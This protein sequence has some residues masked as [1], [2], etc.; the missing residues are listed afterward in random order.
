MAD[1]PYFTV[2]ELRA[3][4]TPDFANAGQVPGREARARPRLRRAVVRGR[5]ARR[6]RAPHRRGDADRQRARSCCSC[7]AGPRSGRSTAVTIDGAALTADELAG[8]RDA[9]LR[10]ASSAPCAWPAGADRRGHVPHGTRATT[11]PFGEL[12]KR[13]VMMLAAEHAKPSTIPARATS[14]RP[15]SAA[16]ASARPTRPARPASPTSTPII[17]LLGAD[18]P[19]TG[20]GA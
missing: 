9:P 4:H 11:E 17:G 15:T 2:D 18:K 3:A 12:V 5:R 13:A 6:L 14:L 10:R 8:A 1:A 19:A 20:A 7:R 16:T